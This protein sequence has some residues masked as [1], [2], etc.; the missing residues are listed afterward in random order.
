MKAAGTSRIAIP[1]WLTA[2]L[3]L[4]AALAGR[5]AA[6]APEQI[7]LLLPPVSSA[8]Q[9]YARFQPL[10]RYL[11]QELGI[12]VKARVAADLEALLRMAR[13]DRPQ[14]AYLCPLIYSRLAD[15]GELQPLARLKRNGKST[16]RAVVVVRRGSPYEA[17]AELKGAR[18][19]YGNPVC[20]A[21]R[22]VPQFMFAAAGIT[23]R[24]DFFEERTLG[25]NENALYAVA[26][27]LFDATAV[28]EASARPFLEKGLVRAL[29]YSRPIPQY[30]L[31]ANAGMAADLA[32]RVTAA[33]TR[34]GRPANNDV[35]DALEMGVDGFVPTEDGDYDIIRDMR[36]TQADGADP[37]R[38]R[39][40]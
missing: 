31:A 6:A 16:F 13:A 4:L 12:T 10:A 35:L 29:S 39:A 20:A 32:H 21:S 23:P 36:R 19:A 37:G 28:D 26:A 5:P 7:R 8:D 25:S 27:D 11:S 14:L 1:A 3:L 24:R 40:P 38:L 33:L 15:E 22:L 2:A 9:V 17:V 18:F 34:L 30:L